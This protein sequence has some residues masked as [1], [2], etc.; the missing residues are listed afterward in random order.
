[1]RIMIT[2]FIMFVLVIFLSVQESQAENHQLIDTINK[3]TS[4]H[5]AH[6]QISTVT[7]NLHVGADADKKRFAFVLFYMKSC[8][9]CQIFDPVLESYASDHGVPVLAYTLDGGILP[10]FPNT[11]YPTKAELLK[12]F[13]S[14]NPVVP[15]VFLI[16][17]KFHK[18][19]PMM[20]GQATRSQLSQQFDL[21]ASKVKSEKFTQHDPI[22]VSQTDISQSRDGRQEFSYE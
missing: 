22:K 2:R 21:L 18:I 11:V 5:S 8:P 12:Y 17:R 19:Y 6:A 4:G 1:M 15:T 16:D 9:H 10:S 3:I 20:R 13:P 7:R 14:Q